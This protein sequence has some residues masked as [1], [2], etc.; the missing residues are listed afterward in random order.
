MK[1]K[2]ILGLATIAALALPAMAEER[3][4]YGD[5]D[6]RAYYTQNYRYDGD[7]ARRAYV[8]DDFRLYDRDDYWRREAQEQRERREQVERF[9]EHREHDGDR[10]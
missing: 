1:T 7:A 9:R 6:Q 8:N 3:N 5:H 4:R 2:I 10:R